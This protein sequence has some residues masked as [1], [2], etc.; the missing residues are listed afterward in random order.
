MA[1]WRSGPS[2]LATNRP[3]LASSLA[4]ARSEPARGLT[5]GEQ[6]MTGRWPTLWRLSRQVVVFNGFMRWI[7]VLCHRPAFQAMTKMKSISFRQF[8]AIIFSFCVSFYYC[9]H[10]GTLQTHLRILCLNRLFS[11][12]TKS[13]PSSRSGAPFHFS[14]NNQESRY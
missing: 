6:T 11:W 13:H 3:R 14:G 1:A 9:M 10:F 8:F 2:T 4:S 5:S 7:V 12:K